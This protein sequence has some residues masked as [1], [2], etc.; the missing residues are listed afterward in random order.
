MIKIEWKSW[1]NRHYA[2]LR[3]EDPRFK[4]KKKI[5]FCGKSENN[6]QFRVSFASPFQK[7]IAGALLD[8][9]SKKDGQPLVNRVSFG[10]DGVTIVKNDQKRWQLVAKRIEEAIKECLK[11]DNVLFLNVMAD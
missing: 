2:L 7:K 5:V 4:D 3:L 10:K 1:P 11:P 8:L 6:G 9:K